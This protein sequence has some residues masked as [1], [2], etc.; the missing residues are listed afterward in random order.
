MYFRLNKNKENE[1]KKKKEEMT[2]N[3]IPNYMLP[4]QIRKHS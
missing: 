4:F 3:N 2:F 1:K